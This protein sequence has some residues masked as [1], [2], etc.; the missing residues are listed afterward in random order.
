MLTAGDTGDRTAGTGVTL[1]GLVNL[2]K[3]KNA[4]S[5]VTQMSQ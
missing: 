5:E 4:N 2:K 1:Q 3:I